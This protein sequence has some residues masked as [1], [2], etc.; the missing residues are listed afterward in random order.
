MYLIS[1]EGYKNANVGFLT[2]KATGREKIWVNMKEIC[3]IC[4]S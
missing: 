3:G 2:I 4:D 1:A